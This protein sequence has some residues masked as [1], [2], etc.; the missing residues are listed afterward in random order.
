MVTAA[1]STPS[2]STFTRAS[3]L[4]SDRNASRSVRADRSALSGSVRSVMPRAARVSSRSR[5]EFTSNLGTDHCTS[6]QVQAS[7]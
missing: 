3:C 2:S 5:S 7:P 1:A 4:A 6:P